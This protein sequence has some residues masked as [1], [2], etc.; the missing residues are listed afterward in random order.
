[1]IRPSRSPDLTKVEVASGAPDLADRTLLPDKVDGGA[2][3]QRAHGAHL[4]GP[5]LGGLCRA[6]SSVANG[7]KMKEVPH[8]SPDS[9]STAGHDISSPGGTAGAANT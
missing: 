9:S 7:A 8:D 6:S 2:V 5:D 4:S 1:M 3:N